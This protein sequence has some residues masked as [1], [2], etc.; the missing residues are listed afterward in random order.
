MMDTAATLRN[1]LETQPEFMEKSEKEQT[2]Q[3]KETLIEKYVEDYKDTMSKEQV[4][5]TVKDWIDYI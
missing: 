2:K 5:D 1:Q 4:N 3:F